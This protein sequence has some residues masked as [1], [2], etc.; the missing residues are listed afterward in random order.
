MFDHWE[1]FTEIS[2]IISN[3]P[4]NI[5]INTG[6]KYPNDLPE[7]YTVHDTIVD[8]IF[9]D[10]IFFDPFKSIEEEMKELEEYEKSVEIISDDEE[11]DEASDYE[12]EDVRKKF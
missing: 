2:K 5:M 7:W 10:D 6:T 8:P 9:P 3:T 4:N 11:S 12:W 1:H